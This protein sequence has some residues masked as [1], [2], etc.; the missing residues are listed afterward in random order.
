[1]GRSRG[2][3][4]DGALSLMH[5]IDV[6][7]G[8]GCVGKCGEEAVWEAAARSSIVGISSEGGSSE[9]GSGIRSSSMESSSGEC[10]SSGDRSV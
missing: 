10:G 3:V 6:V 2:D 5:A 9:G 4:G 7:D 1:M 8:E